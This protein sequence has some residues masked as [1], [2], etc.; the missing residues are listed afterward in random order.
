[1]GIK[2]F[3]LFIFL[4]GFIYHLCSFMCHI[5]FE[6]L[7]H[8]HTGIHFVSFIIAFILFLICYKIINGKCK[9]SDEDHHKINKIR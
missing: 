7:L 3:L 2:K 1:M 6:K 9:T 5:G 4:G 8:T